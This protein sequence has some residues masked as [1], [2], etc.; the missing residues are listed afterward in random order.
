M[1]CIHALASL[2][3]PFAQDST[4]PKRWLEKNIRECGIYIQVEGPT[5]IFESRPANTIATRVSLNNLTGV[6]DES[7]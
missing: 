4:S 6:K 1:C 2:L 5:G 7:I 3:W